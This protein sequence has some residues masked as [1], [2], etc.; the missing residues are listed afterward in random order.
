MGN[1]LRGGGELAHKH[2]N[3][4]VH[5]FFLFFN[6]AAA[7]GGSEQVLVGLLGLC[8][9]L[10]ISRQDSRE[11]GDPRRQVGAKDE[12]GDDDAVNIVIIVGGGIEA[13]I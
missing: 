13:R 4:L 8:S 12:R 7:L 9:L 11:D 2:K 1:F 6:P 5:F 3:D 10:R